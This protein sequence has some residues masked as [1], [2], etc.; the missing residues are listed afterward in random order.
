MSTE[1]ILVNTMDEELGTG[2][3]LAVH[4]EGLLHRAFSVLVFNRRGELLAQRRALEKYHSG[5]LWGN[6]CCGH[7][8]PGRAIEDSAHRRLL[9]EMG[10]ETPLTYYFRFQYRADVGG[11]MRE[12]EL[13]HVFLG[14]WEGEPHPAPDEVMDWRWMDLP[15]LEREVFV[16]PE[17]FA[18]WLPHVLRHL[19][20]I[21]VLQTRGKE[22]SGH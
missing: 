2:E 15:D 8:E 16:A 4:R 19:E 21:E 20:S 18:A 3:K 14:L 6:T 7:A 13:D 17:R 22:E 1:L 11:G 5:G 12:H 9:A 10:I